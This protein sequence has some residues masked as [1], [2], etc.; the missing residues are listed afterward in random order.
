MYPG[1]YGDVREYVKTCISCQQAKPPGGN[2]RSLAGLM[3]HVD[4]TAPLER[5][6]FDVQGPLPAVTRDGT[7]YKHFLVALDVFSKYA[8]LVPLPGT[9]STH[10]LDALRQVT[11][12]VGL[13]STLQVDNASYFD[14]AEWRAELKRLNIDMHLVT[15]KQHKSNGGV[16]RVQRTILDMLRTS[17]GHDTSR[18]LQL[19]PDIQLWYNTNVHSSTGV[20]P[21]AALHTYTASTHLDASISSAA[22]SALARSASVYTQ[23]ES[24]AVGKFTATAAKAGAARS[25]V[26][27][28]SQRKATARQA[29]H[30][31]RDRVPVEYAP[32]SFVFI[33][34]EQRDGDKL[35]PYLSGPRRVIR[36]ISDVI[37]AVEKGP[38][39]A[40]GA[41]YTVHVERLRRAYLRDGITATDVLVAARRS[42][43][44]IVESVLGY[45]WS[46]TKKRSEVL[47]KWKDF[48]DSECTWEPLKAVGAGVGHTDVVQGFVKKFGVITDRRLKAKTASF[49]VDATGTARPL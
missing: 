44:Y 39:H 11:A 47:V 15:P 19:L 10:L 26:I 24:A 13:P 4:V 41:E 48:P 35:A 40:S 7:T 45:R 42:G 21:F 31:D 16:E 22:L 5:L 12:Q 49:T 46:K 3:Q 33:V 38:E 17:H 14:S 28:A 6:Q 32:G 29:K 34:N 27:T 30:H 25:K 2:N 9:T 1:I 37:Y 8:V 36:K 20:T 23:E 43:T 18:W